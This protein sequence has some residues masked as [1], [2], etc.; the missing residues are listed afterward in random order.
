MDSQGIA[1]S[2]TDSLHLEGELYL[3]YASFA[4]YVKDVHGYQLHRNGNDHLVMCK[5]GVYF[6]FELT[7]NC[8]NA[9]C[10]YVYVRSD[11]WGHIYAEN[12]DLSQ[13]LSDKCWRRKGR[14]RSGDKD[15]HCHIDPSLWDNIEVKIDNNTVRCLHP[16]QIPHGKHNEI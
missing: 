15:W 5:K 7:L 8:S 1:A 2:S 10:G 9:E 6:L 14:L 3:G 11:M 16:R 4:Y 13:C 12:P